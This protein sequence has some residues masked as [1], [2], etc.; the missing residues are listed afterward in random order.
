MNSHHQTKL[1]QKKER[2]RYWIWKARPAR[3]A[4]FFR[5][6]ATG[7]LIFL[8]AIGVDDMLFAPKFLPKI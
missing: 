1:F 4:Y 8:F 5:P 7:P 2:S 6:R 3:L